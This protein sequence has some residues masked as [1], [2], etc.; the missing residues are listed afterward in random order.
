MAAGYHDFTAG[1]VLT[2]ANLED[3]C[4]NQAV[5]RFADSA[6]RDTALST[7]KTEGMVSEQLDSNS[8]TVYSG[9]AW[10]T[11]GPL[12]GTGTSWTPAVTQS[13]SVSVTVNTGLY[14]RVGRMVFILGYLTVTGT[15]TGANAVTISLPVTALNSAGMIAGHGS[16]TD[17]SAT[18]VYNGGLAMVSTTTIGIYSSTAATDPRLGVTTFTAALANTDV[19]TFSGWYVAASDA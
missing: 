16:I 1:E 7:V 5:M 10:S 8:L 11:V 15:G 2:A 9:S 18:T 3:Y 14:W 4:Q 6:T 19:I 17:T 12:Y 13:G